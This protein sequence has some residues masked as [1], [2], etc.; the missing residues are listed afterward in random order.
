MSH[1]SLIARLASEASPVIPL[2][3]PYVRASRWILIAIGVVAVA[4]MIKGLR[5]NWAAASCDPWFV[6]T[7]MLVLATG[8]S[9]AIVAMAL[10]VPGIVQRAWTR[11]LPVGILLSWGAVLLVDIAL[12]WGSVRPAGWGTSC[13]WK[14]WGIGIGPA[15]VLV[16]L[17]ARAAP[18]DWR[19]T[20]GLAALSALAFG[21]LGTELICPV[22][23]PSHLF[24]WHFLPVA[25]TS[26]AAFSIAAFW[27]RRAQPRRSIE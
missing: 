19:W 18:L 24:T 1:E 7:T 23:T 9:A 2:K 27:T 3:A 6:V 15:A 21:V 22:T 8:V 20:G 12:T 16:W 17:A 25:L 5:H 13:M 4:V 26:A 10:S 14:T 11:W